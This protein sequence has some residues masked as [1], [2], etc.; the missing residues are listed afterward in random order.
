MLEIA[1]ELQDISIEDVGE[2]DDFDAH[3]V[4][5]FNDHVYI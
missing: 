1:V 4:G 2:N 5:F 3:W